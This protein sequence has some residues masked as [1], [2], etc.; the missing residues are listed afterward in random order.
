MTASVIPEP[1][2]QAVELN[3]IRGFEVRCAGEA[4]TIPP[5][6]QRLVSFLA[7]QSKP[8]GRAYI[9]GTLWLDADEHHA[10]ASLRSALWRLHPL[11]LVFASNTHLWLNPCVE[12]DLRRA[13]GQAMGVLRTTSSDDTMVATA[14]ELIDVGE[15]LLV[16]WYDDWVIV[17]RERFRQLRLH[18]MDRIG[19]Q[20]IESGRCY[21]ALQV[22]LAVTTTEPLRESAHR[23]LVRV[24]LMQGNVAEAI[25]QYD[26][27]VALLREEMDVEPSSA[28]QALVAPYMSGAR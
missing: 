20:L 17:E 7:F 9:S 10:S 19:E 26:M 22:G 2:P 4:V 25:R 12:V 8:V 13:T 27:Y 3:L 21:D 24:H 6:S 15:D 16:G 23:L 28:I 11:D 14:R 18:A 1:V 5:S